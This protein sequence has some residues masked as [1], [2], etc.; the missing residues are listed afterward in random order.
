MKISPSSIYLPENLAVSYRAARWVFLAGF[1]INTVSGYEGSVT[2]KMFCTFRKKLYWKLLKRTF[3]AAFLSFLSHLCG[4]M[5]L[6]N[7]IQIWTLI[8][9]VW[10]IVKLNKL[11][12]NLHTVVNEHNL[13]LR[14]KLYCA[15]VECRCV[16]LNQHNQVLH[17]I[18]SH[19]G[20]NWQPLCARSVQSDI[21]QIGN[22]RIFEMKPSSFKLF[23]KERTP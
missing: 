9:C 19:Y 13:Q 10:Y 4:R 11:C 3:Q 8:V 6:E 21:N 16:K 22:S 17:V 12:N 1:Q 18:E 7:I 23:T 15:D 14:Q 2:E 20:E 5:T